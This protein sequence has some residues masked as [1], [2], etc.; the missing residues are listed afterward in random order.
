M[1]MSIIID[2][3]AK[4]TKIWAY[5]KGWAWVWSS[6][7]CSISPASKPEVS[8]E[9]LLPHN[10]TP[11][12]GTLEVLECLRLYLCGRKERKCIP[13]PPIQVLWRY[14]SCLKYKGKQTLL[15]SSILVSCLKYSKTLTLWV[16][17]THCLFVYCIAHLYITI[18]IKST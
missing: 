6:W 18:D 2:T 11:H 1:L 16:W 10:I 8:Q 5:Q 17:D 15:F 12:Y 7:E 9:Q 13:H 14:L 4:A 3:K